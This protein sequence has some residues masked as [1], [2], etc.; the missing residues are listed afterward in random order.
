MADSDSD[1]ESDIVYRD[2]LDIEPFDEKRAG[3]SEERG[4]DNRWED[5]GEMEDGFEGYAEPRRVS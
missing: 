3:L 1:D 5:E 2:A 4:V